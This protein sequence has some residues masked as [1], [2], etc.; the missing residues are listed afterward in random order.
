MRATRSRSTIWREHT[1]KAVRAPTPSA[2][3][4]RSCRDARGSSKVGFTVV[5][6]EELPVEQFKTGHYVFLVNKN[7]PLEVEAEVKDAEFGTIVRHFG[8]DLTRY[9]SV[10]GPRSVYGILQRILFDPVSAI[11]FE[12]RVNGWNRTIKGSRNALNGAVDDEDEETRG[13][14]L[15]HHV[16]M[17]NVDLGDY[18]TIGIEYWVLSRLKP[19][20]GGR[21][22][23]KPAENFVDSRKPVIL[24]HNG[25]NQ[26]EISGRIVKDGKDGADLPFLQTQGRLICHL[27][28]DRLSPGAKR[29]LFASTREQSREGYMLERI[30]TELIGALKADD[31]L[32]RLNEEAREQSLREKD[33]EAQRSMRLRVAKLLRTAGAALY[34][35]GGRKQST[36]GGREGESGAESGEATSN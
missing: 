9:T 32:R 36:E 1:G 20:K 23:I 17:F 29:L 35:A 26:G 11:R 3:T 31:E 27:N 15:D 8:Y 24:T 14:T 28:C 12:N 6:Y 2:S 33:E 30:R 18:G 4:R 19:A 16:P 13:P 21:K 10:L 7:V 25:Q 34:N 22:R 5:K